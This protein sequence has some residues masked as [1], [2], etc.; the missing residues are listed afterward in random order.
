[1]ERLAEF[2]KKALKL[3][4]IEESNKK[5]KGEKRKV[6]ESSSR[7]NKQDHDQR[8][9]RRRNKDNKYPYPEERYPL[10]PRDT[11]DFYST[12]LNVCGKSYSMKSRGSYPI[13]ISSRTIPE[14]TLASIIDTSKRSNTILKIVFT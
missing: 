11:N 13:Q 10:C 1:M 12:A 9:K 2:C 6:E 14:G 4:N 7:P 5:D 8:E 3:I